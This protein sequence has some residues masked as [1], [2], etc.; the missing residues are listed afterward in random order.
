[1]VRRYCPEG[2]FW[3]IIRRCRRSGQRRW[4]VA[5]QTFFYQVPAFVLV[6][7]VSAGAGVV[8]LLPGGEGLG[9]RQRRQFSHPGVFVTVVDS[10]PDPVDPHSV[11]GV[12]DVAQVADHG[13]EPGAVREAFDPFRVVLPEGIADGDGCRG[14]VLDDDLGGPFLHGRGVDIDQGPFKVEGV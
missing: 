12:V 8:R 4:A 3:A 5:S 13:V 7:P 10:V 9:E 6:G 2:S 11:P 1:M 14:S